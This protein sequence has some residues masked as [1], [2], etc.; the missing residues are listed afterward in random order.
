M[1]YKELRL[2]FRAHGY[3]SQPWLYLSQST[4]VV[5]VLLLVRLR[6]L[7]LLELLF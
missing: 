6:L 3:L 5:Y 1:R 4:E 7:L 2:N